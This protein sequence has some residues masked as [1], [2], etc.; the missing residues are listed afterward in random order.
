MGASPHTP[1]LSYYNR[2][3]RKESSCGG[4]RTGEHLPSG[5][6]TSSAVCGNSNF[7]IPANRAW[8]RVLGWHNTGEHALTSK[9]TISTRAK[10]SASAFPSFGCALRRR[11]CARYMAACAASTICVSICF[12]AGR[13]PAP[14]AKIASSTVSSFG[15]SFAC[16]KHN[17]REHMLTGKPTFSFVCKNSKFHD[18]IIRV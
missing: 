13:L 10:H 15:C 17:M 8:L 3:A 16:G 7:R 1:L 2:I 4:Q 12:L 5:W 18:F 11:C 14:R 9:L 6:P